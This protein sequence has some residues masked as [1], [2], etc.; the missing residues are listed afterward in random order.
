[1]CWMK[2]LTREA[3]TATIILSPGS[4]N[5]MAEGLFTRVAAIPKKL[6]PN[7]YFYNIF[8]V[9]SAT[10]WGYLKLNRIFSIA[11]PKKT[12]GSFYFNAQ[13]E[14]MENIHKYLRLWL[15]AACLV[16]SCNSD[17]KKNS[18]AERPYDPWEIGRASCREEYR[19]RCRQILS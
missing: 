1:S 19:L 15:I 3:K 17:P 18:I 12:T 6:F 14:I 10:Q 2:L 7:H 9:A 4:T 5:S 13:T 11:S 16:V 8:W